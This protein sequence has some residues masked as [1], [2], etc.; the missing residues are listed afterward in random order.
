[1][2]ALPKLEGKLSKQAVR[3]YLP[4]MDEA[5]LRAAIEKPAERAGLFYEVG[6][7]DRIVADASTSRGA[8]PLVA[9]V[10]ETL[11]ARREGLK[12]TARAYELSGGVGGALAKSAGAILDGLDEPGRAGARRLLLRLVKIGRGC[13]DNPQTAQ[14]ETALLAAG[15][16]SAA[17]HVLAR[18]S[19]GRD[20]GRAGTSDMPG[21]LVVV[22]GDAKRERVDLVH[23]TPSAVGEDGEGGRRRSRDA[24]RG[25]RICEEVPLPGVSAAALPSG[26]ASAGEGSGAARRRAKAGSATAA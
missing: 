24:G 13:E 22:S 23:E 1:M 12:L 18:L 7:I 19:G 4:E 21:R 16:G 25:G 9:H 3:F 8:L 20:V 2:T 10:L 5:G 17:E 15:G 14:R 26:E 6:L 11:H